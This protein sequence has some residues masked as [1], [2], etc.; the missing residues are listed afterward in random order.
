M[1][2]TLR[3]EAFPIGVQPE[4]PGTDSADLLEQIS[5]LCER[6]TQVPRFQFHGK[7]RS[8]GRLCQHTV[9]IGQK[10]FRGDGALVR[11]SEGFEQAG[12]DVRFRSVRSAVERNRVL[13]ASA[14][15][16]VEVGKYRAGGKRWADTQQVGQQACHV[17]LSLAVST[18]QNGT[19]IIAQPCIREHPLAVERAIGVA[20]CARGWSISGQSGNRFFGFISIE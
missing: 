4:Q 3:Y 9:Y 18:P 11:R 13:S 12:Q 1:L 10:I 16:V 20:V 19:Q 6:Y 8:E 14:G 17:H 5:G 7:T 15:E 2:L